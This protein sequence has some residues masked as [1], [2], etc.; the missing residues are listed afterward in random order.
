M[1]TDKRQNFFRNE[2]GVNRGSGYTSAANQK[3]S[4]ARA[5]EVMVNDVANEELKSLQQQGRETGEEL[6]ATTP[7]VYEQLQ[8]GTNVPTLPDIPE[9]L[10][11]T[12]K[13]TYK[14]YIYSRYETDIKNILK[15]NIT[16]IAERAALN[17]TEP[18]K[19]EI[20]ANLFKNELLETV[21]P[22]VRE[23][24][25]S[26]ADGYVRDNTYRVVVAKE[27]QEK[28]DAYE[29]YVSNKEDT[30]N[31][32]ITGILTGSGLP[33]NKIKL[34]DESIDNAFKSEEWK[35]RRRDEKKA[36]IKGSQFV[37]EFND[38]IFSKDSKMNKKK[39][40]VSN[41]KKLITF[42]KT[43][44]EESI[45]IDERVITRQDI[46]NAMPDQTVRNQIAKVL[47]QRKI[48][49]QAY[50]DRS[51]SEDY[52]ENIVEKFSENYD[53]DNFYVS[54]E[55]DTKTYK[56]QAEQTGNI[57]R[58]IQKTMTDRNIEPTPENYNKIH[59]KLTNSLP[60]G[61]HEDTM[62]RLK[63]GN[64]RPEDV[65]NIVQIADFQRRNGITNEI[66]V[67]SSRKARLNMH[68]ISSITATARDEEEVIQIF[69][70]IQGRDVENIRDVMGYYSD[71]N[72]R[73]TGEDLI[74]KRLI[75]R[76]A[77][78]KIAI[79]PPALQTQI[80][81]SIGQ[82]V[83]A[84]TPGVT[85]TRYMDDIETLDP[86]IDDVIDIYLQ[87]DGVN[88]IKDGIVYGTSKLG[89]DNN[90][91]LQAN[92]TEGVQIVTNP[93]EL[94]YGITNEELMSEQDD[95]YLV[96]DKDLKER[97]V[98]HITK[99]IRNKILQ[100]KPTYIN[101]NGVRQ[102]LL[103]SDNYRLVATT[104]YFGTIPTVNYMVVVESGST[105][106]FYSNRTNLKPVSLPDGVSF[107]I[108]GSDLQEEK[109]KAIIELRNNE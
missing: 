62:E 93:P 90:M 56:Y 84:S 14:K 86:T 100:L 57:A 36:L 66:L 68:L 99:H 8:D 49:M 97:N 76:L 60:H 48:L 95:G 109:R 104:S 30:N 5:F 65:K 10:G 15:T 23:L 98:D 102:R 16:T 25:R 89:I 63:T 103:A 59:L 20:E 35:K 78:K 72:G 108:N 96:L 42:I 51:E 40:A 13:E 91:Y 17:L 107:M 79:L 41:I 85:R 6:A 80:R 69:D 46:E 24:I 4:E 44:T 39:K 26:S 64:V 33:T 29:Y 31:S 18:A 34:Y 38:I 3:Q 45:T 52:Y 75:E 11:K 55:S 106:Q 47:E 71:P 21:S 12:A 32:I 105:N 81:Q 37:K 22:K 67:G 1:A 101:S 27:R 2:V 9:Y 70:A 28:V 50:Q 88:N 82:F 77:F 87:N 92:V 7:Y 83:L 19:Y 74:N 94:L 43:P 53:T 73:M 61:V 54:N 58:F